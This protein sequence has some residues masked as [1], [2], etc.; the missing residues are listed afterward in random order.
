MRVFEVGC[1]LL[2]VWAKAEVRCG[3]AQRLR[4]KTVLK[5]GQPRESQELSYTIELYKVIYSS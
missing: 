2:A 5:S 4:E 3:L 1:P